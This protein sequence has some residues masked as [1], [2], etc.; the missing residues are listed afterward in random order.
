MKITLYRYVVKEQVVPLSVCF[1]GLTL[2]LVTARLLQ[3]TQFLFTSSLTLMDLVEVMAFAMPK[4]I[5]FAL[6]MATLIGVLLAFLRLN[7]DNEL[8]VFRASGLSFKQFLPAILSVVMVTT[9]L[10]FYNTIYVMPLANKA[11]E[12]KLKSLRRASL[13][14]FLKDGT[15]ID[16]IPNLV[17]FFQNVNPSELSI[18]G[19][20]V[21]DQRQPDVRLVIV[22]QSAR[23][24]YDRNLSHLVFKISNGVITRIPDNFSD[25]QA[26]AFKTYDLALSL[27]ALFPIAAIDSKNKKTMSLRGL[28]DMVVKAGG[29]NGIGYALEFNQR[30]A[31]PLSC[32]LLGLVGAPLGAMFRQRSRMTGITLGLLVYLGYYV[33]LSAGKG[34]GENGLLPASLAMWIPN[35]FTLAIAVYLWTKIQRETSFGLASLFKSRSAK[36]KREESAKSALDRVL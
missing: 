6:P 22:A 31:L 18:E 26:V 19:V 25:A 14:V 15:F 13:P 30:V 11:F 16:A 36:L 3:L 1:L 29:K 23:I 8:I 20:F 17:F 2:I 5:L 7:S 10:S 34:L 28:Y 4:L 33:L 24:V 12:Y 35:L 21:Q 27:D 32:L 9:L